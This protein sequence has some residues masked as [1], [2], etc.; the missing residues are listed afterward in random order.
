MTHITI[1]VTTAAPPVINTLPAGYEIRRVKRW[2]SDAQFVAEGDYSCI[3]RGAVGQFSCVEPI[4]YGV[5][6]GE[7]VPRWTGNLSAVTQFSRLNREDLRQLANSQLIE[8]GYKWGMTWDE[9]MAIKD[10]VLPDGYELQRKMKWLICDRSEGSPTN[11]I[12][13]ANT[14]W[15]NADTVYYGT[16]VNAGQP[17]AVSTQTYTIKAKL[18]NYTTTR[19]EYHICKKLLAFRRSDWGKLNPYLLQYATVANMPDNGYGEYPRG[20]VLCPVALD[21][22]DFDFAGTFTP[23]DYY[24]PVNWLLEG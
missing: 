17:V 23:T 8:H 6:I 21:G 2:G 20:H 3:I 18:K 16:M 24:L 4:V 7:T 11:N 1:N 12:M 9:I 19:Q 15:Y 10:I 13:W 5:G 22:R 14:I